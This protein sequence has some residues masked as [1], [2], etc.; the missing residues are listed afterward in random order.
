MKKKVSK[1]NSDVKYPHGHPSFYKFVDE[2]S[3]LHNDKNYSYAHGG[4]PLGNFNRVSR[5]MKLYK[6]MSWDTPEG[7]AEV[8]SLKQLDAYLWLKSKK[9]MDKFEGRIGRIKDQAVY[10]LIQM[11]IEEESEQRQRG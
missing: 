3:K 1:K 11:C 9:H 7:V 6:G 10:K 8:Y 5:I 4:P 2:I